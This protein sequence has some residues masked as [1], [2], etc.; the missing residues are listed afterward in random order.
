MPSQMTNENI[1][2]IETKFARECKRLRAVYEPVLDAKHS[3]YEALPIHNTY[4]NIYDIY[5]K[6]KRAFWDVD[7]VDFSKDRDG[8]I[9]LSEKEQH[10][11]KYVL[12]FFAYSD[13]VVNNNI[14]ERFTED[15]KILS[16]RCFIGFR[17]QWKMYT[18]SRTV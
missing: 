18:A 1:S 10:F 4:K 3:R 5:L 14:G 15:V 7:E 12:A 13:A 16:L 6:H 17:A 9:K 11:V 8:F 2:S